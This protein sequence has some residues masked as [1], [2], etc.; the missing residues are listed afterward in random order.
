MAA[1]PAEHFGVAIDRLTGKV[2][3]IFNPDSEWEFA[4]HYVDNDIEYLRRERKQDW[5]VPLQPNGMTL[6]MA[7]RI[8]NAI[9]SGRN[10]IPGD[11]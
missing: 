3:R 8:Q 10:Y 4:C 6:A 11:E 2:R 5:G 7:W 1:E 9:E